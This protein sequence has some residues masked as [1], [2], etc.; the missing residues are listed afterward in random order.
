MQRYRGELSQ[1]STLDQLHALAQQ[2]SIV[3]PY[4]SMIVLVN[5]EQQHLLDHLA[6]GSDRYQR[7][8]EELGDT[9]P[10]TTTP[11]TGVPEPH[12][13]L[14]IGLAVIMLLLYASRKRLA[15]LRI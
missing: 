15:F 11:L 9:L 12:E 1:I 10:S 2:Y 7:E 4:S 13:W 14:L 8:F 6:E 3:T 5:F